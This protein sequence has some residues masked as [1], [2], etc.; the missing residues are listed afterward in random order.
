[1]KAFK[2]RSYGFRSLISVL[3]HPISMR[4]MDGV[5]LAVASLFANKQ[6]AVPPVKSTRQYVFREAN[7]ESLISD[8]DKI[9][10]TRHSFVR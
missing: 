9:E 3:S 6:P 4:R 5:F 1:M 10:V 7:H 2:L 8:N